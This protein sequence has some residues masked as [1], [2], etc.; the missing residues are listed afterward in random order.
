MRPLTPALVPDETLEYIQ[1]KHEEHITR[2]DLLDVIYRNPKDLTIRA[3]ARH[4]RADYLITGQSYSGKNLFLC[5]IVESEKIKRIVRELNLN[6]NPDDFA[7]L[8][9]NA[10][11]V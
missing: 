8:I 5:V 11:E 7:S 3:A 2:Q 4:H 6:I 1:R 9:Y 10:W